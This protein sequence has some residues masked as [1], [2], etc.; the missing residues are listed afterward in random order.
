MDPIAMTYEI[1]STQS[2]NVLGTFDDEEAAR[3][4]VCEALTEGGATTRDL[5]VYASDSGGRPVAEYADGTL[6]GW[7]G[8]DTVH[9]ALA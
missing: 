8:I 2:W 6:A 1:V 9:G 5:V 4:A 3:E 7:A